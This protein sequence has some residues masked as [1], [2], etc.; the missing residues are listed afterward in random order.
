M[1]PHFSAWLFVQYILD[2]EGSS[3]KEDV[4]VGQYAR[5]VANHH[6]VGNLSRNL[7]GSD[8]LQTSKV[9]HVCPYL[10]GERG[11]SRVTVIVSGALLE[12]VN[13]VAQISCCWHVLPRDAECLEW[14]DDR[15]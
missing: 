8:Q 7:L 9:L 11:V 10:G 3:L 14:I 15:S 4:H 1:Q 5:P 2:V 12:Q 13:L 6:L